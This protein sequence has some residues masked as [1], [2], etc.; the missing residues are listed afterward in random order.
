[1]K[2]EFISIYF[3]H[4]DEKGSRMTKNVCI[5]FS[6]KEK[7]IYQ[8]I[9]NLSSTEIKNIIKLFSYNHLLAVAKKEE[10]KPTELI[11]LRLKE[12]LMK[13][14]FKIKRCVEID[15]KK[16]QKWIKALEKD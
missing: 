4:L 1:M 11:K 10:R 16:F 6:N 7:A 9:K 13:N 2:R 3:P 8:K 14:D 12:N 15:K 5:A